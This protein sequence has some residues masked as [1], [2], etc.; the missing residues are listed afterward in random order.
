VVR[1]E[2]DD[3]VRRVWRD[4]GGFDQ[5]VDVLEVVEALRR[6]GRSCAWCFRVG[7]QRTGEL[8]ALFREADGRYLNILFFG[9]VVDFKG[10]FFTVN[11]FRLLQEYEL[12]K[13]IR[14]V[15][16]AAMESISEDLKKDR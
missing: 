16:D 4:G 6:E 3:A 1:G 7:D 13:R 14:P 2:P 15:V 5:S 9:Q 10:A 11:N 8:V 12:G